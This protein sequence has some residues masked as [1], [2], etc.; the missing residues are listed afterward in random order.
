MEAFAHQEAIYV[1][2][3]RAILGDYG[4]FTI[5]RHLG[6][7]LEGGT[8]A[9]DCLYIRHTW[10]LRPCSLALRKWGFE[11]SV[12][13]SSADGNVCSSL[14]RGHEMRQ[15]GDA[16]RCDARETDASLH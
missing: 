9:W 3:H 15:C 2:A 14:V 1:P 5:R 10:A 4:P 8:P 16:R 13:I 6:W 7:F 11:P 12:R